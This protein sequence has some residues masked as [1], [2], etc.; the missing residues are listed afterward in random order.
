M[1]TA[2]ELLAAVLDYYQEHAYLSYGGVDRVWRKQRMRLKCPS[3]QDAVGSPECFYVP[4]SGEQSAAFYLRV[5]VMP[6][7]GSPR[8]TY[9]VYTE[10]DEAES[11]GTFGFLCEWSGKP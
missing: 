9:A 6:E 5:P 2:G 4:E 8:Y 1:V 7:S 11:F 10:E 3:M